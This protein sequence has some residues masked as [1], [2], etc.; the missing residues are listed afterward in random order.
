[1][2]VNQNPF[3]YSIN[4]PLP[5]LLLTLPKWTEIVNQYYT[6]KL[7]VKAEFAEVDKSI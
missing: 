3:D 6:Q 2:T 5:P 7:I 1:M 4:H